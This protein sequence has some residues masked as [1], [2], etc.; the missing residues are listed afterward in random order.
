MPK[1]GT[2]SGLLIIFG[3]AT[4]FGG[5]QFWL[6]FLGSLISLGLVLLISIFVFA[7]L[8]DLAINDMK[9]TFE[10]KRRFFKNVI[11]GVLSGLF[12][13]RCCMVLIRSPNV[14]IS[15]KAKTDLTQKEN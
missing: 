1:A 15:I 11:D 13:R 6:L 12:F 4:T 7:Y 5:L 10:K 14:H 9:M 8:P 2:H 3:V